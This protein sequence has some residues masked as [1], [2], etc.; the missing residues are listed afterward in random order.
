[1]DALIVYN[2][3]SMSDRGSGN[4]TRD[5]ACLGHRRDGRGVRVRC[6]DTTCECADG[7][8]PSAFDGSNRAPGDRCANLPGVHADSRVGDAFSDPSHAGVRGSHL[9]SIGGRRRDAQA[10]LDL[11]I[12][13]AIMGRPSPSTLS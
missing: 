3:K 12:P 8:S 10:G 7:T 9:G 13:D 11:P 1:M 4:A 2:A 5:P 6:A